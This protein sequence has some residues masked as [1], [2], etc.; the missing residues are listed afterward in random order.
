MLPVS[1]AATAAAATC[2][3]G[4]IFGKTIV[5]TCVVAASVVVNVAG[6]F[7]VGDLTGSGIGV[8][9]F[10]SGFGVG[11]GVGVGVGAEP[12]ITPQRGPLPPL[13]G[14]DGGEST[15]G[16]TVGA[17]FSTIVRITESVPA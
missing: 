16:V 4:E 13:G 5:D 10:T 8:V 17:T 14:G 15:V 6:L 9:V 7:A 1:A 3:S 2:D 11:V 12:N